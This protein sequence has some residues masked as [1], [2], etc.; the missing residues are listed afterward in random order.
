VYTL[1]H[2]TLYGVIG[3]GFRDTVS[4]GR[5]ALQT[6]FL[7]NTEIRVRVACLNIE[8]IVCEKKTLKDGRE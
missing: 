6:D 2:C 4:A 5:A 3:A 8:L 1:V 7:K